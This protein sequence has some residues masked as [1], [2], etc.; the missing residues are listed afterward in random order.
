MTS[1]LHWKADSDAITIGDL[2]AVY[3]K[4]F[5]AAGSSPDAAKPVTGFVTEQAGTRVTA[6]D[7]INFENKIV[8]SAAIRLGAEKFMVTKIADTALVNSIPANQSQA[9]LSEFAK[10]FSG[11]AENIQVL[12]RVVLMPPENIHLNSFMYELILD[13]SDKHLRKLYKNVLALK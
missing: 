5:G 11:E 1:L 9:L 8:L 4:T 3:S 7:R 13:V 2:D 6:G 10:R 12:Q